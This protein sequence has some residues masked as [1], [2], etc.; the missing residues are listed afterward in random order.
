MWPEASLHLTPY[1]YR[2]TLSTQPRPTTTPSSPLTT[3]HYVVIV[4]FSLTSVLVTSLRA[5]PLAEKCLFEITTL[6]KQKL[7]LQVRIS[8]S[9][10]S[11]PIIWN[12]TFTTTVNIIIIFGSIS[13]SCSHKF[14]TRVQKSIRYRIC[15]LPPDF[16]CA[17]IIYHIAVNLVFLIFKVYCSDLGIWN[18]TLFVNL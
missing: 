12:I 16:Y 14:G 15:F 3:F 11:F 5:F 17:N 6:N 1:K 8:N 7:H 13:W 18:N 10:S 4:T 9:Q 2:S